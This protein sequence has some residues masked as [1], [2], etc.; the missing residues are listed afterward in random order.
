MTELLAG[1]QPMPPLT[2]IEKSTLEK[3]I[4]FVNHLKN[5]KSILC[6]V[7]YQWFQSQFI[8]T[9]PYPILD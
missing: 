8:T 4:D 7:S 9:V 6:H 1:A 3:A 2:Q 5:Q